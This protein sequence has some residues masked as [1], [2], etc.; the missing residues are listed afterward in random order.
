M[1]LTASMMI[2][3]RKYGMWVDYFAGYPRCAML[4]YKSNNWCKLH[5]ISMKRRKGR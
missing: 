2:K 1:I 3:L 5:G 4:E